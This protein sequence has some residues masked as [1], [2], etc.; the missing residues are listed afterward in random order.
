M[1][2]LLANS[3]A[4]I[5]SYRRH[6]IIAYDVSS[7]FVNAEKSNPKFRQA[8]ID[9]FSNKNTTGYEEANQS[10]LLIEHNN[11]VQFFDPAQDEISFFHFNIADVEFRAL[12]STANQPEKDITEAFN[13]IF[14]KN[15][16]VNWTDFK[17]G[18]TAEVD[19]YITSLFAINRSPSAFNYHVSMSNFV[20]PLV[21]NKIDK[22][23]YAK[24]YILILLSDFLS[25]SMQGNKQ[26]YNRIKEAYG[27]SP[28]VDPPANTPPYYVKHFSDELAAR[29][30]KTDFFD[31]SFSGSPKPGIIGFKIK[32]QAGNLTPED[33]SI[34]VDDDINIHQKGYNSQL[35]RVSGTKIKFTHNSSLK[36]VEVSMQIIL[37]GMEKEIVL[38]DQ[39]IATD[40]GGDEWK[41]DYTNSGKLMMFDSTKLQYSIPVLKIKLDSLIEKKDIDYLQLR[42]QFKTSYFAPNANPLNYIYTAERQLPKSNISFSTRTKTL[43]MLYGI[44]AIILLAGIFFLIAYGR[45]RRMFFS[46]NGYLDSYQIIDYKKVGK[47]LT[48]Y[49][50]WDVNSDYLPVKGEVFYKS[51]KF[52]FNWNSHVHL[53]LIGVQ[54][55]EGFDIYLKENLQSIRE[56]SPGH[57]ME[58]KKAKDNSISFFVCLRQNDI[59][60]K[61]TEPQLAKFSIKATV[62]DSVTFIKSDIYQTLDYNFHL[63]PDLGDVWVGLDP[64]TSGSCVAVGSHGDDIILGKGKNSGT[65]IISSKVV[66]D[67]TRDFI[68]SNGHIPDE[69]YF[70]GVLAETR[71]SDKARSISFQSI[72]KLLGFKNLKEIQFQNGNLLSL[73]GKQLS[74]L[75]V[76]GLYN[77]L[78]QSIDTSLPANKDY[79]DNSRNFDPQRAVV[80]IPNN[81]TISK[82]QDIVDCTASLNQFKEIRYVYEAE[83]VLFYYLSNY[84]R[85]NPSETSFD[86]ETILVFD[87]GGA[88]INTTIVNASKIIENNRPVY[89][90]DFLSKIGYGIGGDTIDYCVVKFLLSFSNEYLEFKSVDISSQTPSLVNLAFEIKKQVVYNYESGYDY[91]ITVFELQRLINSTLKTNIVIEEDSS[92]YSFFKK[93]ARGHFEL[94]TQPIFL[95]Y[96]YNNIKDAVKEVIELSEAPVNKVIF[97][98]RST[99][100]PFV[101]E[102]V[103]KQFEVRKKNPAFI[104][105]EFEESKTAVAQGAC[106]YGI[107]KNAVR[108]NNLKTNASFGIKKTLSADRTDVEFIELV[109][110]GCAFDTYSDEI[111]SFRGHEKIN[112]DFAFDGAKVN[113]YQIMGKDADKILSENQKHKFSKIADIQLPLTATEIAIKVSEDDDIE[114]AVRLVSDQVKIEKGVV[115]DQ[116]ME[117]ANEEHYTWTV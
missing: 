7:P 111:G 63:G 3:Y 76:K 13:N 84:K 18:N 33:I 58:L 110:M 46:I 64:G 115:S 35:F 6:F 12:R 70:T 99:F 60:V 9:L 72:K 86:E 31:F 82:I 38:F 36:P 98:G 105:L 47:L 103:K 15:K 28:L 14:L 44:P 1:L 92:L 30:Y 78:A 79:L 67:K 102:T 96:I 68:S 114:C 80:A 88:T 94:F 19:K 108:L 109:E 32:P 71:S 57:E 50:Y 40:K 62:R 39:V 11:K 34:F 53:D 59:N 17:K 5:N 81:F 43:I 49:K 116:E 69:I 26:D 21:L 4:Q 74:S 48:P 104:N 55:P 20:Y 113:F 100:F 112:D 117:D 89:S 101:K 42:Y 27:F 75:L 22:N 73:S 61:I 2:G 24:E 93:N 52:P 106:W 77:F 66:F 85:F 87:M 56:Y 97:S 95:E 51:R 91:L 29:Y 23:K 16:Q 10:N 37:H 65:A 54:I 45:P 107:N 8:L 41:S 25:G 83:A 90:I